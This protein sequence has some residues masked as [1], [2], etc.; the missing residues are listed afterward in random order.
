M[1]HDSTM[2]DHT[3]TRDPAEIDCRGEGWQ[4]VFTVGHAAGL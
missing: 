4:L 3:D 1:T 2:T